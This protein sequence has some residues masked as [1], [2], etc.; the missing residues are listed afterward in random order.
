MFSCMTILHK[1][2]GKNMDDLFKYWILFLVKALITCLDIVADL[3]F[4][5]TYFGRSKKAGFKLLRT[6]NLLPSL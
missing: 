3:L 2:S 6:M 5:L 1:N 4:D